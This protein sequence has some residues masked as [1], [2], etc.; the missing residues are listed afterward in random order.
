MLPEKGFSGLLWIVENLLEFINGD[1]HPLVLSFKEFEQ[2][3]KGDAFFL[4]LT[5]P[6]SYLR[7]SGNRI[8]AHT[9][10]KTSEEL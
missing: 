4:S 2:L 10:F 1:N 5:E 9:Q 8:Q 7:N 3:G 6:S